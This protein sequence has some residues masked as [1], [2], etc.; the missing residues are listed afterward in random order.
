[1]KYIK[2]FDERIDF[3][4]LEELKE[5]CNNYLSYL[6]D[7][8]YTLRFHRRHDAPLMTKP[9]DDM[10]YTE[11]SICINDDHDIYKS[12]RQ[13]KDWNILESYIIPFIQVLSNEYQLHYFTGPGYV[14]EKS[15]IKL[16]SGSYESNCYTLNDIVSDDADFPK[17]VHTITIKIGDKINK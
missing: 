15:I 10:W 14:K 13:S 9:T 4:Y 2:R 6:L 3:N 11:L 7:E 17:K 5:F 8:S 1:M 12:N 16:E